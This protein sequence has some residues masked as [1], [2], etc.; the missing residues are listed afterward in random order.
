[1]S[2]GAAKGIARRLAGFAAY[3]VLVLDLSDVPQIDLTSAHA[4][5]DMINGTRDR[6]CEVYLAGCRKSISD[7]LYRQGVLDRFDRERLKTTRLEALQEALALVQIKHTTGD[8]A[9]PLNVGSS[10]V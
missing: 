5:D 3:D 10:A 1:M 8:S 9:P 6:G 7:F 2:F 4:L